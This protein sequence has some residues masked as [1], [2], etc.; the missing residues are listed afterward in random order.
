MLGSPAILGPSGGRS[1]A[2]RSPVEIDRTRRDTETH[3]LYTEKA[4]TH[5]LDSRGQMTGVLN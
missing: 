2:S 3:R 5:R 1:M 4:N